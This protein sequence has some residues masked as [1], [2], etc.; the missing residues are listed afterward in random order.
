M[1]DTVVDLK[2]LI[3]K[4]NKL[5]SDSMK[6]RRVAWETPIDQAKEIREKQDKLWKQYIFYKKLVESYSNGKK[7]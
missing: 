6:M 4:R 1:S 7:Y 2:T 3:K 5:L